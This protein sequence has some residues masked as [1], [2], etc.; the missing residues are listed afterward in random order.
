M[1][2]YILEEPGADS[3]QD[4]G[5]SIPFFSD[6]VFSFN[7]AVINDLF[8]SPEV[9]DQGDPKVNNGGIKASP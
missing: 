2:S 8:F 6:M 4:R 7:K 9:E 1:L 3:G 5:H